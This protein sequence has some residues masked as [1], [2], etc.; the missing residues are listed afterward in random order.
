MVVVHRAFGMPFIIY[1]DDHAPP[2]V[3]VRGDGEA[4]VNLIGPDGKPEFVLVADVTKA[5]QRR[6]L[7][8]V[9]EKQDMLLRHW[10]EIHDR[11]R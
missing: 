5:D 8:E 10:R 4:K 11:P 3:H 2:H 1:V 6:I 9:R 7:R